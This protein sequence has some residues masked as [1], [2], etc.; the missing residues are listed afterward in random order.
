MDVRP[1]KYGMIFAQTT[2]AGKYL[3]RYQ[4]QDGADKSVVLYPDGEYGYYTTCFKGLGDYKGQTFC[5]Y[6]N[7]LYNIGENV[8]M[9]SGETRYFHSLEQD[10]GIKG[11]KTL[12]ALHFEG[13]VSLAVDI[14]VDG[15]RKIYKKFLAFEDGK[16]TL[17]L[18]MRGEK[19]VVRFWAF[20]N[21]SVRKM[22][23]E[24]EYLE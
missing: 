10:F 15:V 14:Y 24:V 8:S 23:A 1:N 20:T 2:C 9:P 18:D 4:D 3:L 5:I 21:A 19:F 13:D 11:K 16:A 6:D 7:L 12:K 22:T 17:N